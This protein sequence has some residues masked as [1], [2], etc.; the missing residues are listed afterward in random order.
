M[1]DAPR[2]GK[3]Q[4]TVTVL[5]LLW[6]ALGL[7]SVFGL[8]HVYMLYH[9]IGLYSPMVLLF[10]AIQNA[11]GIL[12]KAIVAYTLLTYRSSGRIVAI[13]VSVFNLLILVMGQA[14]VLY[15]TWLHS[16]RSISVGYT[17]TAAFGILAAV[18][19]YIYTLVTLAPAAS[20]RAWME[21]VT[22]KRPQDR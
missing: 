4:T 5:G 3:L 11:V 20:R 14:S 21:I 10:P 7:W 6:I 22:R 12:L 18:A 1:A 2:P 15:F 13:V 8:V 9:R 17:P 16:H 19:I